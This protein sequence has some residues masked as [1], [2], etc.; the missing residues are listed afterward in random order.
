MSDQSSTA[1]TAWRAPLCR[2]PDDHPEVEHNWDS[3]AKLGKTCSCY[4]HGERDV[5]DALMA[6]QSIVPVGLG[7][8]SPH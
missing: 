2:R 8:G 7:N 5:Q 1:T 6:M 4:C 3:L